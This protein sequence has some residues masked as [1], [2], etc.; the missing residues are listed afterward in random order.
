MALQIRRQRPHYQVGVCT[1]L[2]PLYSWLLPL[3]GG[4]GGAL[5]GGSSPLAAETEGE[6]SSSVESELLSSPTAAAFSTWLT[7]EYLLSLRVLWAA[8][9]EGRF[10]GSPIGL[11]G[12]SL[13]VSELAVMRF[14]RRFETV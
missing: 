7:D 10:I 9:R 11:S 8:A 6:D 3:V 1:P 12:A 5:E 2:P 13:R 4:G 14:I